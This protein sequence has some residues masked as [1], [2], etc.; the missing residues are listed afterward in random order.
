MVYFQRV[1]WA[2][3]QDPIPWFERTQA[4]AWP[5]VVSLLLIG[6]T[7]YAIFQ[8]VIRETLALMWLGRLWR[9]LG[10]TLTVRPYH[11]DGAGGWGAVGE[12]ALRLSIFLLA[13]LLFL[14][15]GGMLPGLRAGTASFSFWNSWL[16]ICLLAYL[17]AVALVLGPLV[18]TPHRVMT[19]RRAEG[20]RDISRELER[21]FNDH[22]TAIAAD[23]GASLAATNTRVKDLR[24]LRTQFMEDF[25]VWP[26]NR[27]LQVK[28]GLTS[29]PVMLL[30][31]IN[32]FLGRVAN[33]LIQT[34]KP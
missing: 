26:F 13:L 27:E 28:L 10:D 21:Q 15:M 29:L 19:S 16:T 34:F 7:A 32:Y 22:A 23:G 33:L 24:G 17:G 5:R 12:H 2:P 1:V 6:A 11:D 8:I 18:L 4:T 30:P 20:L 9:R 25:P 31:G 14:V 3:G